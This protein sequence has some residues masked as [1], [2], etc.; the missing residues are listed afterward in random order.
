MSIIYKYLIREFFK[1]FL[2]VIVTV[3]M[4]YLVVDFFE[5]TDRFIA[6]NIS[7]AKT[8]AFF[9]YKLPFIIAQITPV[10]LLLSILI[11]FGLMKKHNELTALKSGGVSPLYLIKPVLLIGVLFSL[12]L[13]LFSDT[14]VPVM[15]D[16][17]NKIWLKDV[18]KKNLIISRHKNIWIKENRAIIHIN[19]YNPTKQEIFGVA[20]NFFDDQFNLV[21]RVDAQKAVFKQDHW[22]FYDIMDQQMNPLSGELDVKFIPERK[23]KNYF[24]PDDFTKVIRQADEMSFKQLFNYIRIIE[25]EGYDATI[26]RVDLYAKIAF[27]FVCL[28]LSLAGVGIAFSSKMGQSLPLGIIIGIGIAFFYW[29]SHSF[30]LSLGYGEII[31]PWLAAWLTNIIF[32][33]AGGLLFLDIQ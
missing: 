32:L 24:V 14:V 7:P 19:Y 13:F 31:A 21:R 1:N 28:I 4:I 23:E 3:S 5:K 33:G 17:A 29:L 12:W 18:K 20:L 2:A 25:R 22:L 30:C 6:A 9:I 11:T 16:R 26:Y 10:G 15:T 8:I 27:P